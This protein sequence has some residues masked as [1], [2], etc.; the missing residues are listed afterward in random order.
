MSIN[1]DDGF[2]IE[3][4][5]CAGGMGE[6]FR[7]AGLVF[8]MMV[9]FEE[10]HCDS[11]ETNLGHRPINMDARD[12]LRMLEMGWRPP[13]PVRFVCGDPPC[14]SWSRAGKRLGVNDPR[15]MLEGTCRII[16]LLQPQAYLIGNVPGL[17]DGPNLPI[18]QRTIGALSTVGY[19]TADFARLDACNYG[20][21]QHRH[22][23]FWF[24]HKRGPCIQWPAPTHG[25][26]DELRDQ[27]TLPGIAALIPWVT[28]KQAL[29]HL[30]LEELGR[31]IKLRKRGANTV[32]HGS[33][34][35]R[36]ART[37]GTSNLSDGNVILNGDQ[38][39][40]GKRGKKGQGDRVGDLDKPSATVTRNGGTAGRGAHSQFALTY[41]DL[42]DNDLMTDFTGRESAPKKK[43]HGASQGQRVTP[44]DHASPA[45]TASARGNQTIVDPLVLTEGVPSSGAPRARDKD[46]TPQANRVGA[47]D[48]PSAT[49]T[50][51]TARKGAG[52]HAVIADFTIQDRRGG[53]E[54]LNTLDAP[55]H[56]LLRN[57]HG[58]GSI[59]LLNDKHRPPSADEPSNTIRGGGNGHSAPP[60]VIQTS[61]VLK[62]DKHPFAQEGEPAPTVGNK[63]RQSQ[64]LQWSNNHP[65]SFANE[66]AMTQRATSGAGAVRAMQWPWDRPSTTVLADERLGPPGHHDENFRILTTEG[67]GIVISEKAAA[68]LQGFPDIATCSC[69]KAIIEI[70]WEPTIRKGDRCPKCGDEYQISMW[71]FL[72]ETKKVRWSMLGQAMPAPLAHAVARQV[73]DQI[74]KTNALSEAKSA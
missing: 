34:E 60:V 25:D 16:A 47:P 40:A 43:N 53:V 5:S 9:D 57:T 68:I 22:R 50:T 74:E 71:A 49:V 45:I 18:T 2:D 39:R 59:L 54:G 24:G 35:E 44:A 8:D 52:Q 36:P 70:P 42:V 1:G 46:R 32:Q 3:I 65:P 58:N 26:P 37:V 73:V 29:G 38:P 67:D 13:R 4:F 11:Y 69:G 31:P 12:L 14:V 61:S 72:G 28:C 62:N 51:K 19:C 63:Q 21:P 30:P 41:Q 7:R 27:E 33:V 48:K 56:A 10:E 20:V 64:V 15:D 55:S 17:D 6:G 66:P 23:P